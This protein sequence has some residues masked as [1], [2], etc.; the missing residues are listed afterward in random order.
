MKRMIEFITVD[1]LQWRDSLDDALALGEITEEQFRMMRQDRIDVAND[2][3]DHPENYIRGQ[4]ESFE[5]HGGPIRF[6]QIER[7]M[8]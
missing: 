6:W 4:F 1:G 5:F 8:E 2:A 7:M 3:R